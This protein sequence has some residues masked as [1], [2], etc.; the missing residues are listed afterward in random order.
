MPSL[1]PRSPEPSPSPLDV[2]FLRG[3]INDGLT[4]DDLL[5]FAMN[6]MLVQHSLLLVQV[7]DVRGAIEQGC[8]PNP[9]AP[10]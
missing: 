3:A 2:P 6:Q 9:M 7:R 8:L 4:V 5:S 10:C 1:K